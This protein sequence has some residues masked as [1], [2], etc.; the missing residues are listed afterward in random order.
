MTMEDWSERILVGV[1]YVAFWIIL[2]FLVSEAFG[3]IDVWSNPG[4]A[5]GYCG[6]DVD[7]FGADPDDSDC[8]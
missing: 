1:L 7:G 4:A 3:L 6:P 5:D 8:Y 2:A